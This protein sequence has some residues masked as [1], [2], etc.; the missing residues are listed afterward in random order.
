[1]T[2]GFAVMGLLGACVYVLREYWRFRRPAPRFPSLRHYWLRGA[3]LRAESAVVRSAWTDEDRR[4]LEGF[5]ATLPGTRGR[6]R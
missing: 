1:M 6:R 4:W 2:A 5:D 3:A